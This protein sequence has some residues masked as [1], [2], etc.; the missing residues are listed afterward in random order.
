VSH[1]SSWKKLRPDSNKELELEL[2]AD[3]K[4][5]AEWYT[6]MSGAVAWQPGEKEAF[7]GEMDSIADAIRSQQSQIASQWFARLP[8]E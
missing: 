4:I 2:T 6:R 1:K 7:Y 8:E 3:K 5:T